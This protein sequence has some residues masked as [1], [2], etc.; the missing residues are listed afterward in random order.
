MEKYK[1][2]HT[3]KKIHPIF[4]Y[5]WYYVWEIIDLILCTKVNLYK[6]PLIDYSHFT[7]AHAQKAS[8]GGVIS[9]KK[10]WKLTNSPTVQHSGIEYCDWLSI[11]IF[12]KSN[13]TVVYVGWSR[14]N[15][16]KTEKRFKIHRVYFW[17]HY[18]LIIFPTYLNT[19]YLHVHNFKNQKRSN[20]LPAPKPR[21]GK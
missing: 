9:M 3:H 14:S 8:K 15:V 20:N 2:T 6:M 7:S 12:R 10:C 16:R 18:L 19:H 5:I 11:K 13:M 21:Q 1:C 4:L 17:Y